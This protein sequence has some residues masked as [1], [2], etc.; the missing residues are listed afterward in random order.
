MEPF[1]NVRAWEKDSDATVCRKCQVPFG[2]STW[3]HHC[4]SCGKVLCDVCSCHY[5]RV[6]YDELCPNAPTSV[7]LKELQRTCW[8]C[9]ERIRARQRVENE[10]ALAQFSQVQMQAHSDE[11]GMGDNIQT[12]DAI[13]FNRNL[14][15]KLYIIRLPHH[16]VF[17]RHRTIGVDLGGRIC[18]VRVPHNVGPGD[19]LYVRTNGSHVIAHH[20][21]GP[22][23]IITEVFIVDAETLNEILAAEASASGYADPNQGGTYATAPRSLSATSNNHAVLPLQVGTQESSEE[24]IAPADAF[25]ECPACTYHN[26]L[27]A[28]VCSM[29]GTA[30]LQ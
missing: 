24:A 19:A 13:E 20:Q 23:F 30:L 29:C 26:L 22:N 27:R 25:I 1:R 14:P 6:P 3:R 9:A 7:N 5:V 18:H 2:W 16:L 4:R 17:D 12:V 11:G 21:Q 10:E 28:A 8:D 15:S